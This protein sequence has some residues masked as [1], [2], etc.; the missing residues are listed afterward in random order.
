MHSNKL[1]LEY[2]LMEPRP[3]RGGADQ[4]DKRIESR[5]RWAHHFVEEEYI[6]MPVPLRGRG[7]YLHASAIE[8]KAWKFG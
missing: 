1:A 4:R 8:S 3:A 7:I 5:H 2:Q 6:Y